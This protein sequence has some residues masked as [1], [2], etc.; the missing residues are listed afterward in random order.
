VTTFAEAERC[1]RCDGENVSW[2]AP[3]PLWNLVIRGGSIDGTPRYHDMVCVGCFVTLAGEMG[4]VGTWRVT[5]EPD[6]PGLE[7]VTPAGRVWNPETGFWGDP[8]PAASAP[9]DAQ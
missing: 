7:L 3:S 1:H 6:P 5:V 2:S 9:R 4:I 8:A